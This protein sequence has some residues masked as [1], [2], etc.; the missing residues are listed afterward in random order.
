MD[1]SRHQTKVNEA[2]D[3]YNKRVELVQE[4]GRQGVYGP[5]GVKQ[6]IDKARAEYNAV[7]QA[8]KQEIAAELATARNSNSD[9]LTARRAAAAKQEREQ[10]GLEVSYKLLEKRLEGLD[11]LGMRRAVEEARDDWERRVTS[12]LASTH[13]PR[14]ESQL[15]TNDFNGIH[16]YNRLRE[17]VSAPADSELATL[18]AEDRHLSSV[19]QSIEN[20][21]PIATDARLRMQYRV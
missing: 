6:E 16:E 2:L 3:K 21:D 1:L 12:A 19:E 18:E 11:A 17:L 15:T 13:L 20:L 4:R 8:A 10:L 14:L 5:E 9:K 7:V